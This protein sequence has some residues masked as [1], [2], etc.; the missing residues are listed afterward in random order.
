[1]KTLLCITIG[2]APRNDIISS[3]GKY[4]K[5]FNII[6]RGALDGLSKDYIEK[7]FS[8]K[9]SDYVLESKLKSDEYVQFAEKYI[10][11]KI[12][13]IIYKEEKNAD[14]I[15]MLCTGVFEHK[16]IT[17]KN[18]IFPQRLIFPVVKELVGNGSLLILVPDESQI[19]QSKEKWG[20]IIEK[21][22]CI[23]VSPYAK[24]QKEFSNAVEYIEKINPD[25][26]F[27]D[28]MG[29]SKEM[30]EFFVEKTG[31]SVVLGNNLIG[32]IISEMR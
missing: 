13:D 6:Q 24:N 27:M 21:L 4:L 3:M 30:R 5:E 28:C 26:V 10:L 17:E 9:D 12:Q 18:I 22:Y 14:L 15:L 25:V 11:E 32:K 31:K 29:Y 7:N 8:P 16:F 23:N 2:Q 19:P 20:A 1:M